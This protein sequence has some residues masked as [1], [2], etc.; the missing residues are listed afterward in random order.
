MTQ[1]PLPPL[2]RPRISPS[3]DK[4]DR[5]LQAAGKRK[6]LRVTQ[7][8]VALSL[9]GVGLGAGLGL[10]HLVGSRGSR[11]P[12]VEQPSS[13]PTPTATPSAPAS[14]PG[15]LPA[16]E[17]SEVQVP[18]IP[19]PTQF[20]TSAQR[21][22]SFVPHVTA[23]LP[24]DLVGRV[25][26]YVDEAGYLVVLAPTGWHCSALVAADG[27]TRVL[28]APLSDRL[29][30]WPEP[31]QRDA[32]QAVAAYSTSAC[33]GCRY[34]LLCPLLPTSQADMTQYGPC[35]VAP[36]QERMRYLSGALAVFEDPA[37]VMGDGA[38]S[39]GA[40]AAEGVLIHHPASPL[41]GDEA[42]YEETCTVQSSSKDLCDAVLNDYIGRWSTPASDSATPVLTIGKWTGRT[43]WAIY[44]SGDSGNIATGLS[45]SVWDSTHA[46]GRGTRNEQRCVPNCAQGT[47]TPYPVT[48]TLSRPVNGQFT[49]IVEQTADGRGTSE[50]FTAPLTENGA[51]STSEQSSCKFG[52]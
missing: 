19:C 28:V 10:P 5:L 36:A 15:G 3:S 6:R 29:T 39:G 16:V 35:R 46:V 34:Q 12:V 37:Y 2:N 43:P 7:L 44:F 27:G 38:P 21:R 18:L 47:L 52:P 30:P 31:F 20:G 17:G 41:P 8:V 14:S 13:T 51:C 48:I 33:G 45:W 49:L 26:A 42:G 23:K 1:P 9:V 40:Y 24:A 50:T 25:S 11:I 4:L 32:R 22:A